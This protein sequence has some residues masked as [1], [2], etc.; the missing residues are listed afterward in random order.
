MT[1]VSLFKRAFTFAVV[2]MT[3]LW[4]M[5]A[6]LAP[7]MTSAQVSL[8]EG[9][10]IKGES[11]STV[12][13]YDGD[14]R[15]AYP[16]S[17]IYFSWHEDFSDVVTVSDSQLSG[18]ALEGNV[19]QRPG[20]EWIKITSNDKVYA[21]GQDGTLFWIE[22]EEVAEALYGGSGWNT[23]ILDIAD[24]FFADYT[25]GASLMTADNLF[26]GALVEADGTTYLMWDGALREVS[27]AGMSANGLQSRHVLNTTVD[28]SGLTMGDDLSGSSDEVSDVSQ[29]AEGDGDSSV[30]AGDISVSVASSTPSGATLPGGATAVEMA[31]WKFM[32]SG[33]VDSLVVELGG[34]NSS[35]DISNVYIYEGNERLTE[36]RSVNSAT[37]EATF[38]NLGVEVSE[39]SP[40]YL[41]A[42]V[43][44]ATSPSG[45]ETV[46]FGLEDVDAVGSDADVSGSFPLNGN[47]FTLS[48]DNAGTIT[49]TKNGTITDPAIGAA[50]AEI[51]EFKVEADSEAAELEYFRLKIDNAT[52]HDDYKLWDGSELLANGVWASG[53]L[54]DFDLD[55]VFVI[56]DGDSNIFTVTADIGGETGDTIKV[57]IDKDT[58]VT[59][60]GGDFG[61][62]MQVDRGD[63]SGSGTFD[64]SSCTSSAGQCS[65]STVDG[66]DVTFTFNGPTSGDIA[67]DSQDVTLLEF[68]LSTTQDITVKDL[69]LILAADEGDAGTAVSFESE[70]TETDGDNTGLIRGSGTEANFKDVSIR[71]ADTM[72]RL[73][74][75]VELSTTDGADDAYQLLDLSDDFSMEAGASL[76]LVVTVDVDNNDP[77]SNVVA[78]AINMGNISIEDENGD[79]LTVGT[80]IVP[81]GDIN[82]N[83]F[84]TQ[85]PSLT[86]ALASSPT[87]FTTVQGS[88]DVTV[89]G[90]T[91]E[92]GEA[93]DVLITDLTI[94]TYGDDTSATSTD[95]A[96]GGNSETDAEV[97]DFFS[98]C[99]L[100]DDAGTL[101]DGPVGATTSGQ[102]LIFEPDYTVEA[103]EVEGLDLVCDLSNPSVST[104]KY[105]A[106]DIDAA[107]NVTAEDSDGDSVTATVPA[108]LNGNIDS[109]AAPDVAITVAPSGSL[110]MALDSSS[111]DSMLLMAGTSDNWVSSYQFEATNEAFTI[112]TLSFNEQQ[113]TDD[114]NVSAGD[115]SGYANNI[116]Q[117]TISYLD[118]QGETV[119]SDATMSGYTVK[120]AGESIYVDPE[121]D[122]VVDV[123]VD[124]PVT[125][126]TTGGSATTSERIEL[127][128]WDGDDSGTENFKAVGAGSGT[129]LNEGSSGVVDVTANMH[130]IVE[131]R[132][133]ISLHASS[134]SGDGFTPG[135]GTELLRFTVLAEGEDVVMSEIVFDVSTTDNGSSDWN[136][137]DTTSPGSDVR[138]AADMDFFDAA[139]DGN[140]LEGS[141][142]DW[143]LL[144]A[145]GADCDG[146]AADLGFVQLELSSPEVI[147]EDSSKTYIFEMNTTG[148]SSSANDS[149]SVTIPEDP[150][151]AVTG[152]LAAGNDMT[153][154]VSA[155]TDKTLDIDTSNPFGLGDIVCLEDEDDDTANCAAANEKVLVQGVSSLD[156]YVNRGYLGTTTN[157][158][159]TASDDLSYLPS[160]FVWYDD[161]DSTPTGGATEN[162]IQGS[163]LVPGLPL[164]GGNLVF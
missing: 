99:S 83:E 72:Q 62:G 148:A 51:S 114:D 84:T 76:D 153:T 134:P 55:E 105:F 93:E 143:T 128:L 40:V 2:A 78:A 103:G 4:T 89:L 17:N 115:L 67:I 136:Q 142:S 133:T 46:S 26:D 157:E 7:L 74:G 121:D 139:D 118:A 92:A 109:G 159:A 116:G 9:D 144:K 126:R 15:W 119:T 59:A 132:P 112:E 127:A 150:I 125:D 163:Y 36:S 35:T 8:S 147:S 81:S 3:I 31:T 80:E 39:G 10:L 123:Y 146:T 102:Y 122:A 107:A 23:N 79:A 91:V 141:D 64:G 18:I 97:E 65:F 158:N 96:N 27:S 33:T 70:T 113:N 24:V 137:C 16:N 111:P 94:D 149:I 164:D 42:V 77:G 11:F 88:S 98:T 53:D 75:P 57:Y 45:G 108:S 22:T 29:Q 156:F 5:G 41:S 155:Y 54:V 117:V 86:F 145:T 101:L 110:A 34:V 12:Y 28:V 129:T 43:E 95:Y 56:D 49:V 58:D 69:D 50:D 66:G 162:A 154:V 44:I 61:F 32:G 1:N 6:G 37:R 38:S 124:I 130:H 19:L 87:S 60:I 14:G 120:F 161:G 68:T 20:T 104:D 82:G 13:Y 30:P 71:Y 138:E 25:E 85:S 135:T 151:V 106:F 100:Y 73:L 131:G 21:V 63:N 160:S 140:E 47:T 48:A 152:F 52:D 90:L